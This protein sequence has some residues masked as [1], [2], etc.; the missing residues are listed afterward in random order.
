MIK[1]VFLRKLLVQRI[2]FVIYFFYIDFQHVQ[3]QSELDKLNFK[4]NRFLNAII[5]HFLE[6]KIIR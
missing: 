3:I 1:C 2:H 6:K 4:Q 5:Y